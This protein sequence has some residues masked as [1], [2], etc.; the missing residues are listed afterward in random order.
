MSPE[1]HRAVGKVVEAEDGGCAPERSTHGTGRAG[2][3]V[4][5]VLP[6][7]L[8]IKSAEL[9]VLERYFNDL[10]DIAFSYKRAHG[11]DE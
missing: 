3:S 2:W 1:R 11:N 9:D 7:P 5:T 10:I 6:D 4:E 8:P